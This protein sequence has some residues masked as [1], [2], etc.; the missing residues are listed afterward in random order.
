[1]YFPRRRRVSLRF[2]TVAPFNDGSYSHRPHV[3]RRQRLVFIFIFVHLFFFFFFLLLLGV[4]DD[5]LR[6]R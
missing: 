5:T 1:M 4:D 6:R 2:H 3:Q